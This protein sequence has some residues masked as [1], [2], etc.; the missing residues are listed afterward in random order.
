MSITPWEELRRMR[1]YMDES[2]RNMFY[3]AR[4]ELPV[5]LRRRHP[6]VDLYEEPK[7]IVVTA[8]LPGIKKEDIEVSATEDTLTITAESEKE[9]ETEEEGYYLRERGNMKFYRRLPLPKKVKPKQIKATYQNGTLTVKL[10]KLEQE[11]KESVTAKV[12]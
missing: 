12:E 2:L 1:E 11:E 8:D 9:E 3:D 7:E 10:P 6:L 5:V 4:A